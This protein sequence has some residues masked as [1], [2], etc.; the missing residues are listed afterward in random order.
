M[1]QASRYYLFSVNEGNN[2]FFI[3]HPFLDSK[4]GRDSVEQCMNCM[5]LLQNFELTVQQ[6]KIFHTLKLQLLL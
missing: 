5:I 2:M 1:F 4:C 3:G 6:A